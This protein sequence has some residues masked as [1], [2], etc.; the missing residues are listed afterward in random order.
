MWRLPGTDAVKPA[1]GGWVWLRRKTPELM[2]ASSGALAGPPPGVLSSHSV[3]LIRVI[4]PML[5]LFAVKTERSR[6]VFGLFAWKRLVIRSAMKRWLPQEESGQL[7]VD[8]TAG[9]VAVV[10]VCSCDHSF[11]LRFFDESRQ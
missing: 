1:T 8:G 6:A 9:G 2:S 4:C 5:A 10:H 11:S 7:F 3:M